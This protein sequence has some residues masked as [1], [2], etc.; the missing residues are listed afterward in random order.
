VLEE[1]SELEKKIGLPH[2]F[3]HQLITEDDWSFVIKLNALFE[4]ASTHLLASKLNHPELEENLSYIDFGNS[5]FGK[6]AL[7]KKLDCISRD[8]AKFLQLLFELRNKLAHNI[9]YVN[10]NFGSHLTSLDSNQKK[11]FVNAVKCGKELVF[12][13][14]EHQSIEKYVLSHP[15]VLVFLTAS[16]ILV[17]LHMQTVSE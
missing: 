8:E 14:C 2:N 16:E 3:I 4:A 7:L 1:I 15:K 13:N 9:S 5:K 12:W 11:S 10:F 6:V 17:S